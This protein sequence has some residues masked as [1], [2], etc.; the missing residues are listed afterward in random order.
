MS[1]ISTTAEKGIQES[2]CPSL[3][4]EPWYAIRTKPRHEKVV[5]RQLLMD[6]LEVYLPMVQQSREWSDRTKL[7]GLP[8][9]PGYVFVRVPDLPFKRLLILRKAGVIG[10]VGN[11][12]GAAAIPDQELN[13]VR[14]LL[15]NRVPHALHP[16]LNVGQRIRVRNGVLKGIEGILVHI[17]DKKGLLVSI[18]LIQRS[19]LIELQGYSVQAI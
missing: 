18:D 16:Y 1:T 8:L 4:C 3:N 5:S 6:G 9:F 7:V 13:G 11:D 2:A 12:R 15:D 17:C 10:F 14:R 19:L